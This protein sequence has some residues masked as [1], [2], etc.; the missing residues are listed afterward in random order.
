MAEQE[1]RQR[2]IDEVT[3][4]SWVTDGMTIAVGAPPPMALLRQLI[5]RGIKEL[6]VIDSGLSLDLLIA[7]GCVRKVITYYAGGGFG[8]PVVP[9]FRRAAERGEIEVWECEEGI[10]T[11]GLQ[12]A[13]QL[14]PF[15]PWRG[16]VGT[17]LPEVNPDL[18][19][20]S[21][22][23]RGETLLAVP[24][25]KPDI[26][27]LH[28][29]TADAY[30]NVQHYGGPGWLDLFLYRAA[31]RTIVQVERVVANEDIRRD[32]WA[33]TIAGA[34]AIVRAPYGAHPFSSRGFYV[35][36]TAHLREYLDAATAAVQSG[37]TEQLT[38]YLNYYCR[39]PVTH[40]DYLERIG[41]KRLLTLYEY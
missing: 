21:D 3:A 29:A 22:P 18:K 8:V 40:G 35:Q 6:T 37:H 20:F 27:L 7:A 4:A 13:A 2:I 39:E 33:T 25:I 30:G 26:A 16:G 31:D 23:I 10:L 19:L 34:D 28:A 14:L 24:A 38:H 15:L 9:S 41:V 36:D 12:A 11:A 32:P 5:R 17:S 1:R